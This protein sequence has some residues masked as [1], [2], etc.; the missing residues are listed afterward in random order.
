[1]KAWTS[2][3]RVMAALNH[4][5][6]DRV[7]I[8]FGG[9]RVTGIAAVAYRRLLEHLG[10]REQVQVYDLKQQLADPSLAMIQ[11]MGGAWCSCTGWRPPRACHFCSW[12]VG[13]PGT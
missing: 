4:E 8:D 7:P 2:R 6:A 11:R 5:T 10:V 9:S 12:T 1:M 13:S 3:D